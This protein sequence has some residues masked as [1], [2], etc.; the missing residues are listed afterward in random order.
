MLA[1]R[2]ASAKTTQIM[3]TDFSNVLIG[4]MCFKHTFSLHVKDNLKPYV[5]QEPFRKEPERLQEQQIL[6]LVGWMKQLKGAA[7]LS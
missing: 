6:A 4:I 3:H 2:I 7:I 5:L 1:N